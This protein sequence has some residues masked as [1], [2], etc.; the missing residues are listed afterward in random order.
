MGGGAHEGRILLKS[1][2]CSRRFEVGGGEEGWEG[3]TLSSKG[4]GAV[5]SD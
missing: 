5:S 4:G 2:W 3:R 1:G